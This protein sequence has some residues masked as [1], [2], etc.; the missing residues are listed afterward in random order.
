MK[1]NIDHT[2]KV[3]QAIKE[4]EGKATA[5]TLEHWQIECVIEKAK[6][7]LSALEIPKK[8]WIDCRITI[9]PE[10]VANSY[11]S[12]AYGT[13]A[14]LKRFSTG[15]FL[16]SVDRITCRSQSYGAPIKTTLSLSETA[17]AAI[18]DYVL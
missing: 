3:K 12:I 11:R 17:K 14:T 8:Y 7:K 16:T 4:A 2:D 15:W 6:K 13:C 18:H 10:T 9:E 5:R 1:I